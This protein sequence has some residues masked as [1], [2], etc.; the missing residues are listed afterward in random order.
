MLPCVDLQLPMLVANWEWVTLWGCSPAAK[1]AAAAAAVAAVAACRRL[2]SPSC[3]LQQPLLKSELFLEEVILVNEQGCHTT[4][5]APAP[6]ILPAAGSQAVAGASSV[7]AHGC[8]P[9][10]PAAAAAVAVAC[11]S[12]GDRQEDGQLVDLAGSSSDSAGDGQQ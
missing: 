8:K 2:G 11:A 6:G 12:D 7:N 3:S 10:P 1:A 4:L 5:P 9:P